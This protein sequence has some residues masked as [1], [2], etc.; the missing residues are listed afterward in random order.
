M[1]VQLM[2][3]YFEEPPE[4]VFKDVELQVQYRDRWPNSSILSSNEEGG[5]QSPANIN[6]G[7]HGFS[8]QHTTVQIDGDESTVLGEHVS[9]IEKSRQSDSTML[10]HDEEEV[11]E[12]ART[13]DEYLD[14]YDNFDSPLPPD[15]LLDDDKG[16]SINL[17]L[18]SEKSISSRSDDSDGGAEMIQKEQT[19]I[20]NE[21]TVELTSIR[22]RFYPPFEELP[23]KK[24]RPMR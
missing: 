5:T 1:G 16:H 10:E 20:S 21:Q 13:A 19:I 17:S 2:T 6:G 9:A 15:S 3:R 7:S 22:K 4:D 18:S 14:H 11:E 8:K 12:H 23:L 24:S